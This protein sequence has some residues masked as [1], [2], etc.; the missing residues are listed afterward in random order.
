MTRGSTWSIG[1]SWSLKLRGLLH[2]KTKDLDICGIPYNERLYNFCKRLGIKLD[3]CNPNLYD[4]DE[5]DHKNRKL[6]IV[7]LEDVL[8]YKYMLQKKIDS[9]PHI[10]GVKHYKDLV[11]VFHNLGENKSREV[12]SKLNLSQVDKDLL[13]EWMQIGLNNKKEI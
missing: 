2:R 3:F 6:R 13:L 7:K 1:G 8:F 12:I 5:I 4:F 10:V 11:N 9:N